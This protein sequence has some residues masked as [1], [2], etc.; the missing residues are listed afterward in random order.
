MTRLSA[1]VA[2]C[3]V[4]LAAS[5][6][7]RSSA[8]QFE[9]FASRADTNLEVPG[10]NNA[11]FPSV[12]G[13][14]DQVVVSGNPNRDAVV[15]QKKDSA[16]SFPGGTS[17]GDAEGQADYADTALAANRFNNT[18]HM[19]WIDQSTDRI[20]YRTK[21][22]TGDWSSPRI[23]ISGNSFRVFVDIGVSQDGRIYVAWSEDNRIRYRT[24]SDGGVNWSGTQTAG[25]VTPLARPSVAGGPG[26]TAALVFGSGE[27]NIYGG[28]WN[29]SSFSIGRIT[30]KGG[31]Q[32]FANPTVTVASTGA[33]YAA[34]RDANGRGAVY[35]SER[36]S[37]GSWPASFVARGPV[38]EAVPIAADA[39]G[40]VHLMWTGTASGGN[41]VYYAFK[42]VGQAFD[43]IV[44]VGGPGGLLA[45]MAG[46]ATLS[47]RAYGHGVLESF[48]GGGLRTRY[49]LFS[50]DAAGVCTGTITLANGDLTNSRVLRG[51]ITPSAG[52]TPNQFR[53]GLNTQDESA[54]PL[55]PFTG[56]F[57]IGVPAS[58]ATQCTHTISVRLIQDGSAGQWFSKTIKVDPS[59]LP[60]PVSAAVSLENV[61]ITKSLMKDVA[62][63]GPSDGDP[64]YTRVPQARLRIGDAG[65]CS[66]LNTFSAVDVTDQAIS[67]ADYTAVIGLPNAAGLTLPK[68]G[69]VQVPVTVKDK[70]GNAQTFT[71]SIIYDPSDDDGNPNNGDNGRGRPQWAAGSTLAGD[72]STL[73]ILRTIAFSGV[74]VTDNLYDPDGVADNNNDDFWGVWL[75]SEYLGAAGAT[76]PAANP[77]NEALT[78]IPAKVASRT[79]TAA[80]CSFTAPVNLFTGLNF[81]PDT[82]K[83]GTYRVYVRVLDGAGN[84]SAR[85][86][87]VELTLAQGYRLP[88]VM[89]N[90][91]SR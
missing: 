60:N 7:P 71:P 58:I 46:A 17:L 83:A 78:W 40:N 64:A 2:L 5:L 81:G 87:T 63:N 18:F 27:G 3:V 4:M 6:A 79:C 89:L 29:G 68:P 16:T 10:S 35:Y 49:Y 61:G 1:L 65:D 44:R 47:D 41:D 12:A 13:T 69:P 55:N 45:N 34:W 59:D 84:G 32:Y 51:T 56:S 62:A 14:S 77:N 57:E 22:L 73:S 53:I 20:Y 36:Q 39:N 31:D 75:A 82:T 52:C 21:G 19:A 85:T 66:G 26:S 90:V 25:S 86:E 9:L 70:A 30:N 74:K 38:I 11:K 72:D 33:V 8:A 88:S 67:A 80:G 15:W 48:T 23:V 91:I 28:L 76:P 43:A 54:A 42:P 37:N 50:S 24:S